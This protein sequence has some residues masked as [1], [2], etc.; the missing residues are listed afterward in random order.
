VTPLRRAAGLVVLALTLS[1]CVTT[2]DMA[3]PTCDDAGRNT[4]VLMAQSVP[5]AELVPCISVL[6]AGWMVNQLQIKSGH[7]RIGLGVGADNGTSIVVVGLVPSCDTGDAVE[8]PSDEQRARRFEDVADV[9]DGYRGVS[10]YL[11]DGGCVTVDFNVSG[12]R[13][14][15]LVNDASAAITLERRDTLE[16]YV[17]DYSNGVIDRP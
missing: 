12:D 14:S 11:F 6:P 4:L 9:V 3:S 17:R 5:D 8:V 10:Y 16:R 15:A 7:T 2:Q 13:W 1:A